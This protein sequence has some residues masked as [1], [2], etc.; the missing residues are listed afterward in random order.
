M[1]SKVFWYFDPLKAEVPKLSIP[2][3]CHEFR[4]GFEHHLAEWRRSKE[5]V[6][7]AGNQSRHLNVGLAPYQ[8]A[9]CALGVG[10]RVT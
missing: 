9:V 6:A 4:C 7:N 3:V 10:W 1:M 8:G 5:N 2:L